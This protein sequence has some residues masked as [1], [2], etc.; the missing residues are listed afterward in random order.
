[1]ACDPES[2]VLRELNQ[3]SELKSGE[4]L[5]KSGELITVK[6]CLFMVQNIHPNPQNTLILKSTGI[7]AQEANMI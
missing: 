1:M 5:F 6:G 7:K 3:E 4:V 2:G